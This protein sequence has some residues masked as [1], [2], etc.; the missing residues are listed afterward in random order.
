[1]MRIMGIAAIAT[2][3]VMGSTAISLT[4]H[5]SKAHG[6]SASWWG[7]SCDHRQQVVSGSGTTR[8]H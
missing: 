4:S 1:M 8:P 3:T 2:A 5:A 6:G 7:L